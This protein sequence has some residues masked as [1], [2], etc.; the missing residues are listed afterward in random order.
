MG[1]GITFP[2]LILSLYY[3]ASFKN[4][5]RDAVYEPVD[6]LFGRHL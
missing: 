3:H 5:S 6:I 4:Q 1:G 2:G